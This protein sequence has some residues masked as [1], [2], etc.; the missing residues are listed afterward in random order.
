[1]RAQPTG[2]RA[3]PSPQASGQRLARAPSPSSAACLAALAL[4]LALALARALPVAIGVSWSFP[5]R[6]SLLKRRPQA[7]PSSGALKLP[8]VCR[9]G[10][11]GAVEASWQAACSRRD[12]PCVLQH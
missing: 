1:V 3:A 7:A 8:A 10:S 6:G 9:P 5:S 11:R 12:Q 4:A 2:E